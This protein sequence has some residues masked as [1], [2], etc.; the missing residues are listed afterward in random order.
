LSDT[1]ATYMNFKTIILLFTSLMTFQICMS[2]AN[3]EDFSIEVNRI[4]P[5]F[6]IT[7][8]DLYQANNI[9]EVNRIYKN[10]WIESFLSV[11][12]SSICNGQS[13]T[14]SGQ[15]DQFT[16]E[17]KELFQ[18]VD[19]GEKIKVRINYIPQN[20]LSK[21]E[22]KSYSFDLNVLPDIDASFEDSQYDIKSYLSS[23]VLDHISDTTFT[24]YKLAAVTF[25]VDQFGAIVSPKV[26]WTSEED[27][28]D[29]RMYDLIC[30]MPKWSPAKYSDGTTVSQDFAF[31]IGNMESCAVNTLNI[32]L[33]KD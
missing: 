24:G 31:T 1:S 9:S 13:C 18:N 3:N 17:Q 6:A 22:P 2:Q 23:R 21:N 10:E 11:E 30:N 5:P 8:T 14:S 26:S 12:V 7:K 33:P 15:N 20:N 25:T 28:L 32:R 4:L 27:K 29:H 19:S 16:D